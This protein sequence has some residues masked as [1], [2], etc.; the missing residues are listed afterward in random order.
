MY[1][2]NTSQLYKPLVS[3]ESITKDSQLIEIN[4]Q[5]NKN[6]DLLIG[7]NLHGSSELPSFTELRTIN[8]ILALFYLLVLHQAY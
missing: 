2:F 1:N 3:N 4:V 5:L 6:L 8:S 7:K